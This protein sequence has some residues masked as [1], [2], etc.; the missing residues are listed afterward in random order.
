M[1]TLLTHVQTKI[2]PGRYYIYIVVFGGGP[3]YVT[4]RKP[5]Q[6]SDDDL[7]VYLQQSPNADAVVCLPTVY[8]DY[9]C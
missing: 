7:E 8:W 4:A 9:R 6:S 3:L 5:A 1:C 2:E